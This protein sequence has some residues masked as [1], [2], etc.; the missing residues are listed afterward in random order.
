MEKHDYKNTLNEILYAEDK[1]DQAKQA[2]KKR[3]A[4]I[5]YESLALSSAMGA[6]WRLYPSPSPPDS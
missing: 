1:E 2:A 5:A 6:C 4:E 3:D